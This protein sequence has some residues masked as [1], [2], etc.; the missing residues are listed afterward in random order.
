[1]MS[2][3]M[4][5]LLRWTCS[6]TGRMLVL[7]EAAE[8]VLHHLEVVV[9]VAGPGLVGQARPGTPGRGRWR[10]NVAGRV[11]GAGGDAPRR[12]PAESLAA[13]SATASATKAQVSRAS[14][15]PLAP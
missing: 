1:M 4:S 6:A 8:G 9:E 2:S 5:A 13:R 14:T 15:S 10:T 7:G 3:G 11:E 12:L